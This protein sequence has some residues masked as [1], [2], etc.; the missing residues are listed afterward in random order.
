MTDQKDRKDIVPSNSPSTIEAMCGPAPVLSTEDRDAYNAM[1]RSVMQAMKPRDIVEALL[2]E[3]FV[4]QTREGLRY[5][6]IK[7]EIMEIGRIKKALNRRAYQRAEAARDAEFKRVLDRAIGRETAPVP[8]ALAAHVQ[9]EDEKLEFGPLS[10]GLRD[11]IEP[12]ER[13]DKLHGV[14]DRCGIRRDR[15]D[16]TG[17]GARGRARAQAHDFP[18]ANAREGDQG[19]QEHRAAHP[20]R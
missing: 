10:D 16:R 4:Y 14:V 11:N 3:E 18:E 6:Q 2:V 17:C 5:R 8:A 20:L 19:P 7:N 13:V 15:A 9:E 1:L 12:Y